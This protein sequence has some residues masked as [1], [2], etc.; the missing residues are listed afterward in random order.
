MKAALD[1][2]GTFKERKKYQR[3]DAE[4]NCAKEAVKVQ[5]SDQLTETG[6]SAR[7]SLAVAKHTDKQG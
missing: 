5:C 4:K 6:K 1:A 3:V 7:K 2:M